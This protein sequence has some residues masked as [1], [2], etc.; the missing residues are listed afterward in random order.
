MG[1]TSVSFE[2]MSSIMQEKTHKKRPYES[3]TSWFP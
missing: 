3:C 2:F 1:K